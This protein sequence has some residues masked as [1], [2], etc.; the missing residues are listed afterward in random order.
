MPLCYSLPFFIASLQGL[1]GAPQTK[2]DL[3]PLKDLLFREGLGFGAL[4]FRPVPLKLCPSKTL[5]ACSGDASLSLK[6]VK[7][8]T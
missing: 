4:F 1:D 6:W 2:A 7:K 8:G 5:K 3:D